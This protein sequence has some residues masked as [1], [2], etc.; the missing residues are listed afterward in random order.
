[1]P[2]KRACNPPVSYR[3]PNPPHRRC[4][5]GTGALGRLAKCERE[6]RR[7]NFQ[8]WAKSVAVHKRLDAAGL[9][10]RAARDAIEEQQAELAALARR[11]GE[12]AL[13]GI[14]TRREHDAEAERLGLANRALEEQLTALRARLRSRSRSP[15]LRSRS[16]SPSPA[17][18][19]SPAPSRSRSRSRSPRLRS[20]SRSPSPPRSPPPQRSRSRSLRPRCPAG[21]EYCATLPKRG[22]CHSSRLPCPTKAITTEMAN[23]RGYGQRKA[24]R[25]VQN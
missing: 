23:I 1:M 8:N 9:G 7:L 6:K 12:Q 10:F 16:R 20:R 25:R 11:L 18:A 15:R 22:P 4:V 17:R 14:V 5:K 21:Y 2:P 13:H 3:S 24:A 19:P